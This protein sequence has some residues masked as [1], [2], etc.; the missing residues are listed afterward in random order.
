MQHH[1]ARSASMA[2]AV[3]ASAGVGSV[4][5]GAVLNWSASFE[6]RASAGSGG[7]SDFHNQYAWGVSDLPQTVLSA[8]ASFQSPGPYGYEGGGANARAT[9]ST[10][11][12]GHLAM[13]GTASASGWNGGGGGADATTSVYF[14]LDDWHWYRV[15]EVIT[16]NVGGSSGWTLYRTNTLG[17]PE[18]ELI[19]SSTAG[20]SNSTS[21]LAPGNFSFHG[22]YGLA[23]SS[24]P[25]IDGGYSLTF[26]VPAPGA[27]MPL[28]I[29]ACALRH[30]R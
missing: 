11:S 12:S 9:V 13:E 1:K 4:A 21:Y 16:G 29:A 6:V 14:G 30:R 20:R 15:T 24:D 18:T 19:A 8:A 27:M 26:V 22:G 7:G 28:L 25:G 2:F 10:A 17:G 23:S 5:S 3:V